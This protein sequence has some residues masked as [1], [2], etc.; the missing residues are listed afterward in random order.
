MPALSRTPSPKSPPGGAPVGDRSAAAR[1]VDLFKRPGSRRG[2]HFE[3]RGDDGRQAPVPDAL[4]DIV[5]Q[6]AQMLAE[7]RSVALMPEER[8]LSTQEAADFLNISRQYLV[9]LVDSGQL[10]AVKVGRHRRMRPTDVAA[11][12]VARDARR[13]A[14]LDRLVTL[15]EDAGGY[16]LDSTPR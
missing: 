14:D 4:A 7:G 16:E 5:R 6:A 10:A 1:V 3:L 12:K 8:L 11:Y 2:L 9:R 15:S 13:I